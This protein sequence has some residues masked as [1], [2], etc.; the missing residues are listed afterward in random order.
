VAQPQAAGVELDYRGEMSG[1]RDERQTARGKGDKSGDGDLLGRARRYQEKLEQKQAQQGVQLRF[2]EAAGEP[3]TRSRLGL[4]DVRASGVKEIPVRRYDGR[5]VSRSADSAVT[6]WE[7][8][9]GGEVPTGESVTRGTTIVGGGVADLPTGYASLTVD[10]VCEGEEFIFKSPRQGDITARSVPRSAVTRTWRIAQV[11]MVLV[12]LFLVYRLARYL[13]PER[14]TSAPAAGLLILA[15]V[16]VLL[17]YPLVGVV[18]IMTGI[19]L[20]VRLAT[21]RL[22]RSE[23][24]A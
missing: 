17:L 14:L 22:Q 16:V 19:V 21:R 1:R 7:L 6:L 15:G 8:P 12:I 4:P 9:Q 11:L 13:G 24:G 10:L 23:A 20:L 18:A 3:L 5:I 2:G